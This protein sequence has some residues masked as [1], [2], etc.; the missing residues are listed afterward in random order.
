MNA[1]LPADPDITIQQLVDFVK[2]DFA[3]SPLFSEKI[4]TPV[5]NKEIKFSLADPDTAYDDDRHLRYKGSELQ[6]QID[7]N[8]GE[9]ILENI[10]TPEQFRRQGAGTKLIQ[11]LLQKAYDL[12]M[13]VTGYLYQQDDSI[14]REELVEFYENLGFDVDGYDFIRAEGVDTGVSVEKTTAGGGTDLNGLEQTVTDGE[15]R[16]SVSDVDEQSYYDVP[17]ADSV[18]A[19]LS[20][21][22]LEMV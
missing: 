21:K 2:S 20:K 19:V 14:S 16:F 12:D 15:I 5:P 18:N 22:I 1:S 8:E 13:P 6:Y 11:A 9:V 3:D 4:P 7:Q 10:Y 17:F